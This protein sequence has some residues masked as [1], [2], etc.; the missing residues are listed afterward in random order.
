MEAS[1]CFC[2]RINDRRAGLGLGLAP[3]GEGCSFPEHSFKFSAGLS[4]SSYPM[5]MCIRLRTTCVKMCLYFRF[6]KQSWI[7]GTLSV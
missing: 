7:P 3:E 4:A 1:M 6:L 5:S 2:I